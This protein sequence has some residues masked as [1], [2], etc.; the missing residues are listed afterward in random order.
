VPWAYEDSYFIDRG[1]KEGVV[2]LTDNLVL[3]QQ[4]GQYR[5]SGRFTTELLRL[6]P[7]G[8][9]AEI[10]YER[11]TPQGTALRVNILNRSGKLIKKDLPCGGIL[12]L[13]EAV[14]LEF[15][16]S[17][18]DRSVTPTLDSYSL[19]FRQIPGK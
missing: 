5:A 17:T 2:N 14:R 6:P 13:R 1:T 8:F 9:F 11:R 15:V 19:S 10:K 18:S 4:G 16:F 12:K 3:D 7:D